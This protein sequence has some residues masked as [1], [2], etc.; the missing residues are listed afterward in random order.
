MD[1]LKSFQRSV[2][3]GLAGLLFLAGVP[4]AAAAA[5][6]GGLQAERRAPGPRFGLAALAAEP[7][8]PLGGGM[9]NGVPDAEGGPSPALAGLLSGLVPGTGQLALG[10]NRGWFYLGMEFV[11][12]FSF[13][14]LRSAGNQSETDYREF[15]DAHWNW[16]RYLSV[17]DCGTGLGPRDFETEKN[18]LDQ[19]RQD[20]RQDYYDS[21]GRDDVY[22]CGWDT[23]TS[24]ADYLSMQDHADGLFGASR[25]VV[26]AV[27][28]N[29][30]VS[31]VDAARSAASRRREAAVQSLRWEVRPTRG[32]DVALRA[33]LSRSF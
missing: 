14:S 17:T 20:S 10:Q 28:L 1:R 24:R 22:A 9:G 8:E 5:P 30:L 13:A 25:W 29:H 27:V 31:A 15:A 2:A 6:G 16:D 21:I 19:Y 11:S 26:A 4:A 23:Q 18:Q 12:W 7:G 32:G 3:P 33:E